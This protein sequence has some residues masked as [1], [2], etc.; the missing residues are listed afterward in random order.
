MATERTHL[1][2]LARARRR[3][4]RVRLR[5]RDAGDSTTEREV[6][7]LGLSFQDGC[8]YA[9]VHCHLRRAVRMLR[10]DRM[11]DSEVLQRA[12]RARP[13]HGFDPAFFASVEFL[14]PGAPVAHLATVRIEGALAAAAPVLFPT[15]LTE[16]DGRVLLCHVRA[17]RL[18]V[19]AAL[20][21]SLG[22]GAALVDSAGGEVGIGAPRSRKR[23]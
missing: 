23:N 19:L 12:A 17:S 10:V 1:L 6:D 14:E 20:V 21:K 13:P 15:A 3:S 2:A 8:W 16:R 22:Q 18:A 9:L 11:V 4:C 7:V 5:Y